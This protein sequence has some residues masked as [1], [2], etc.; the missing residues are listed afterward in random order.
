MHSLK[1]SAT[2]IS[3]NS[4]KFASK[5]FSKKNDVKYFHKSSN[6][7]ESSSYNIPKSILKSIFSVGA[8]LGPWYF[9]STLNKEVIETN[10]T[11][12]ED[13]VNLIQKIENVRSSMHDESSLE[14]HKV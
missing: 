3:N 4:F 10:D 6:S 13:A 11:L 7:F 1:K 5:A 9:I 8:L 14:K 2:T 12:I